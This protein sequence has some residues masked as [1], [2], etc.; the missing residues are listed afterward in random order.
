ML[1]SNRHL[2]IFFLVQAFIGPISWRGPMDLDEEWTERAA[3]SVLNEL[4]DTSIAKR[5]C[6]QITEKLRQSHENFLTVS[7]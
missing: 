7:L 6:V 4:S 1:S 3:R 2:S 5:L